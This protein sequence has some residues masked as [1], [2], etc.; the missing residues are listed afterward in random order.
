LTTLR[1]VKKVVAPL[2][3]RHADLVL[4]GTDIVLRPVHH[5]LRAIVIDQTG[6]ADRFNPRWALTALFRKLDHFP[7]GLGGRLFRPGSGLWLLSDPDI[8]QVL[9]DVVERDA[10]PRLRALGTLPQFLAFALPSEPKMLK[11]YW[12]TRFR[13]ALALGDLDTVRALPADEPED[14]AAVEMLNQ[15]ADGLGSRLR[16][17]GARISSDDR[18]ALAR[19]LHE[20]EAYSVAK[21]K[22]GHVWQSTPFPLE[23]HAGGSR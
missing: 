9:V 22:V 1:Q 20:E 21:L 13:F 4:I 17:Q 6:E 8:S 14:D 7:L 23:L 15:H 5:I 12:D 19:F 18:A 10:L 11:F 16:E 2:L 3:E